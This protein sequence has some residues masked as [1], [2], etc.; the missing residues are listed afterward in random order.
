[1]RKTILTLTLILALAGIAH[2]GDMGQPYV[3]P[4][5]PPPN[6]Q[7]DMGQPLTEMV[8]AIIETAFSLG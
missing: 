4:P 6:A 1:M 8:V 5:P 7:G 2:A 3:P